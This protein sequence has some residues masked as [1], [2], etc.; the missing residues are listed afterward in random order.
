[1]ANAYGF[2]EITGVTAALTSI[3]LMCKASGVQLVSWERKWGGRLVTIIVEG[4]TASVKAAIEAAADGIKKPVACGIL[5]NP[6]PEIIRL[7]K[8]S[9]KKFGSPLLKEG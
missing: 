1:M 9:A 3:D 6:H 4:D 5:S 8:K 7:A 2:V